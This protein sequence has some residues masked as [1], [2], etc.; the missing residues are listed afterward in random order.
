MRRHPLSFGTAASALT[1]KTF[2]SYLETYFSSSSSSSPWLLIQAELVSK[3]V[4][5]VE[6]SKV[7]PRGRTRPS[8]YFKKCFNYGFKMYF[9]QHWAM[10][11]F[12]MDRYAVHHRAEHKQTKSSEKFRPSVIIIIIVCHSCLCGLY[13]LTT[14][15]CWM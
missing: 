10:M 13:L 14:A 9:L 4:H 3:S 12:T 1:L 15:N 2:K 6:V 7:R 8:A 5:I 11:W